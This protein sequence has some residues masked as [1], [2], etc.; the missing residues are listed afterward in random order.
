MSQGLYLLDISF[1][2]TNDLSTTGQYLLAKADSTEGAIVLATAATDH[3]LGVVQNKPK[4]TEAA[5]VRVL[6][7]SK[8]VAGG[9][10]TFGDWVTANGSSQAITT[11]SDHNNVI[12][13]ALASAV[14][15][16]IF[17]IMLVHFTLSA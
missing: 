1:V 14:V 17:E 10:V 15:N 2:S 12:G 13:L 7:T 4:A 9:T 16:D 8:V 11:T 3:I 6:G 5:R